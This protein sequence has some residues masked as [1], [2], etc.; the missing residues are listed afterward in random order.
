MNISVS[1]G[2]R[3]QQGCKYISAKIRILDVHK[4]KKDERKTDKTSKK[5][6]FNDISLFLLDRYVTKHLLYSMQFYKNPLAEIS[7][8]QV[9]LI[10]FGLSP[11]KFGANP[12]RGVFINLHFIQ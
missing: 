5:Q 2:L 12:A 4:S 10:F 11:H 3:V 6:A 7:G 8:S 9:R 1:K